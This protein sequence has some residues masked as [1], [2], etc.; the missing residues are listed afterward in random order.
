M[1]LDNALVLQAFIA[2]GATYF[3]AVAVRYLLKRL[4]SR[5]D[6]DLEALLLA[7]GFAWGK[8]I[9]IGVDGAEEI[10]SPIG[11][12][13]AMGSLWYARGRRAAANQIN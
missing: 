8:Y 3:A 6:A 12:L 5:R 10:G 11:A 7:S 1:Q 2:C 13:I 9:L 4:F